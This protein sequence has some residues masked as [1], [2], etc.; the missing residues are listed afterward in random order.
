MSRLDASVLRQSIRPDSRQRLEEL[1]V[2]AEIDS[3]NTYLLQM[4]GPPPGMFRVALA[5][6]QTAGRGRRN[7]RPVGEPAGAGGDVMPLTHFDSDGQAHMVDVGDKDV[8]ERIAVASGSI[9]MQ[10]QTLAMIL[11]GGHKK[12]DVLGVARIAG[13][14]AAKRCAELIP[15]CHPLLLSSIDV[16]ISL[17]PPNNRVHICTS[18]QLNGAT[19][20]EMEALTAVSVAA[21]TIYDM[22]KSAEKSLKISSPHLRISA[23][24]LK[25]TIFTY[26]E[27]FCHVLS[28]LFS[29]QK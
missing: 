26:L 10:A 25:K 9:R 15:L 24:E 8:T 11:D 1:E 29:C 2:F 28:A 4:P 7:P 22:A 27:D 6:H 19:G 14:Q 16:D 5:D 17:D 23:R 13:I 3:T 12:G 20:V 21:L 18:C